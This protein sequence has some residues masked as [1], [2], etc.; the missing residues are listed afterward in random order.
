MNEEVTKGTKLPFNESS[1]DYGHMIA[2]QCIK[3]RLRS[4]EGHS[5]NQAVIKGTNVPFNEASNDYE[6]MR[7]VQ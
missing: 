3:Q 2:A 7:A 4:H 1:N 5:M 6:H